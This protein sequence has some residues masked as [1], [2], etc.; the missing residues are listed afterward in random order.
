MSTIDIQHASVVLD[1]VEVKPE[2]AELVLDRTWSPYGQGTIE[3]SGLHDVDPDAT[4]EPRVRLRIEQ[5]F[6]EGKTAAEIA[7]E[8][9]PLTAAQIAAGPWAAPLTASQVAALYQTDFNPEP[10][11]SRWLFADL[12]V[13]ECEM[14]L[15]TRKTTL[16]V[17]TDDIAMWDAGHV[18]DSPL[19][20]GTKSV[21]ALCSQLVKL[22]G[23]TLV[24]G[25]V[26][27]GTL[28]EFP[29]IM[30]GQKF[31][32]FLNPLLQAT[33]LRLYADEARAWRLVP[34]DEVRDEVITLS[35]RTDV[36]GARPK[37]DRERG[38][39]DSVVIEYRWR[40]NAGDELVRWDVAGPPRPRKTLSL[41][42]ETPFPGPGAAARV[43]ARQRK[44][45]KEIPVDAQAKMQQ[46]LDAAEQCSTG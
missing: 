5:R 2:R 43:L 38:G 17:A 12:S 22:V 36:E 24:P 37:V 20:F 41:T 35:T 18:A 21:R 27:D 11:A 19:T 3:L 31:R 32:D 13:R 1:G 28:E 44:R 45:R 16:S 30:P 46:W 4:P 39:Y 33:G 15:E 23:G 25:G 7:A 40:N 14:D 8:L 29:T 10:I 34:A 26:V 6:S 9:A 42:Y